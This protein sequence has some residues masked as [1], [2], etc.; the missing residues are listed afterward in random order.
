MR[1]G[2]SSWSFPGWHK[3]VYDRPTTEKELARDGLAAYA[4][5]PLFRTVAVDRGH[6]AV[7]DAAT[8]AAYAAAVDDD[9]AFVVKA[10]DEI[11]TP[12]LHQRHGA[13]SGEKN[14][15]FLDV[16]FALEAT[17]P[18]LEG[19]GKR[20][21]VL[22]FQAPPFDV[23]DAGG[24]G[25]VVD[26]L[27]TFLSALPRER[28]FRVAVELRNPVFLSSALRDCLADVDVDPCLTERHGMPP[29]HQQ[30]KALLS[31]SPKALVIRWLLHKGLSW[32][33][34]EKKY[35]PYDRLVDEDPDTRFAISGLVRSLNVETFVIANNKA[36]GCSP[37]TLQKLAYE[38]AE[39]Q[40]K[41]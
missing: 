26:K 8:C 24:A 23:A 2:T 36:E 21:G 20:L 34:G 18:L 6:Y 30:A 10:V 5:H 25:F 28:H 33:E 13:R 39:E 41:K 35:M 4:Q 3:L 7:V 17:A 27:H 11:M 16:D 38:I 14:P 12:R 15:R 40:S 37:L 1:L 9:F 29:V 19:L 31:A 22:L 32:D